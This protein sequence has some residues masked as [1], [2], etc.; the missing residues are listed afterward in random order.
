MSHEVPEGYV[1]LTNEKHV[2]RPG[3]DKWSTAELLHVGHWYDVSGT[4]AQ[5]CQKIIHWLCIDP[6]YKFI[7]PKDYEPEPGWVQ[8][9]D[10]GHVLLPSVD[11][12]RR[13]EVNDT[14]TKPG[15]SGRT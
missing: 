14:D 8:V 7:C 12:F 13:L 4:D 6:T 10:D 2:L 9:L 15:P 1:E 3:I 5:A 11:Q